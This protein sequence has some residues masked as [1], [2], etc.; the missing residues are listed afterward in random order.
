MDPG[1]TST[2]PSPAP[3]LSSL[4]DPR[5][6]PVALVPAMLRAPAGPAGAH[7][8]ASWLRLTP[9][10]WFRDVTIQGELPFGWLAR[11]GL[12]QP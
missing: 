2:P 9:I 8:R 3:K 5:P 10:E 12:E 7:R 4:G 11:M 6:A 1:R